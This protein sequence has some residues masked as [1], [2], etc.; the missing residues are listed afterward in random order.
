MEGDIRETRETL[1]SSRSGRTARQSTNFQFGK[2]SIYHMSR[3]MSRH[4]L[5][6]PRRIAHPRSTARLAFVSCAACDSINLSVLLPGL[7]SLFIY[8]EPRR[9]V[10]S[11]PLLMS[12]NRTRLYLTW[13]STSSGLHVSHHLSSC[14]PLIPNVLVLAT[15]HQPRSQLLFTTSTS[16]N[17]GPC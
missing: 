4:I 1:P 12:S 14:H 11:S 9:N 10:A 13:P 3:P 8:D 7:S 5:P 16:V 2:M 17:N 6:R 15:T